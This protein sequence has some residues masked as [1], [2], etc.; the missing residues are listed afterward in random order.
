MDATVR[1]P[2]MA[3]DHAPSLSVERVTDVTDEAIAELC[4]AASAAI[5]V[6]VEATDIGG[7]RFDQGARARHPFQRADSLTVRL[8]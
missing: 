4:E 2:V 5:C 6:R 3:R 7:I 1:A 8:T